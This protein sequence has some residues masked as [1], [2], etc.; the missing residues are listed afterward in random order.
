MTLKNVGQQ[1]ETRSGEAAFGM[2]VNQSWANVSIEFGVVHRSQTEV[3]VRMTSMNFPHTF[4][5]FVEVC[6]TIFMNTFPSH[7]FLLKQNFYQTSVF[8]SGGTQ[9]N[10]VLKPHH[11]KWGRAIISNNIVSF[12]FVYLLRAPSPPFPQNKALLQSNK[13]TFNQWWDGIHQP[14]KHQ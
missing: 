12:S 13:A 8:L 14:W 6:T 1:S 3:C 10:R 11:G 4:K 5:P 7:L 2:G 9:W